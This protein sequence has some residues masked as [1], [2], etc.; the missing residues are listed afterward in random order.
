MIEEKTVLVFE[1]S[2]FFLCRMRQGCGRDTVG[3][4][5]V[6]LDWNWSSV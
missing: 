2:R 3:P 6:E 4:K 5:S 1:E